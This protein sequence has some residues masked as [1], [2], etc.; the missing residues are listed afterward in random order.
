[1][2]VTAILDLGGAGGAT[3]IVLAG[4]DDATLAALDLHLADL[5]ATPR[6]LRHSGAAAASL[7]LAA[8]ITAAGLGLA[9]AALLGLG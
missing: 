3:V 5:A 8:A 6:L 4:M 9:A 2:S 1:M 7:G